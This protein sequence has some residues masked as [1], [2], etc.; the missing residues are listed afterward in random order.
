MTKEKKTGEELAAMILQ[1][2]SNMDGCPQAR[3]HRNRLRSQSMEF[4]ADI[5]RHCRSRP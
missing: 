5:W 4:D 3:S 2:L 1:D